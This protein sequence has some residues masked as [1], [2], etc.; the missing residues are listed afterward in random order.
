MQ[1]IKNFSNIPPCA[2]ALGNFDGLHIAHRKIINSCIN[3]SKNNNLKSGVLLFENHTQNFFKKDKISLLTTL[4]E[5]INILKALGV[6][7]I[8][9]MPFDEKVMKMSPEDF[10]DFLTDK[11]NAKAI[12]AG[13][14]YTFGYKAMGN[15][16]LLSELSRKKNIYLDISDKVTLK[17]DVVSS[18]KIRDLIDSGKIK[19]ANE[20]LDR[21][22]SMTGEVVLGKQNGRKMGLPT[23]NVKVNEEKLLPPD[24][25][26]KG[27]TI[28]D[29]KEYKS[30][31]NIGKNPTF[32]AENRTVESHIPGFS[33]N[34]YGKKI[35]VK[36]LDKIRDEKKFSSVDELINQIN[37]DLE[38]I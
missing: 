3:F 1:I 15:I 14:D 18:T 2:L 33:D 27:K 34:L 4:D 8:C 20:F 36:F 28:I 6:D 13:Y 21:P 32:N 24:G 31:I 10:F 11:L 22:Y 23:A 19:E 29:K 30:L 37:K 7:F 16:S 5:K 25:V 12:F 9:L 17:N 26:Y 35:T 38:K